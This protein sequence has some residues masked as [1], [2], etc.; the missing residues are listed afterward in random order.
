[1]TGTDDC[2]GAVIYRTCYRQGPSVEPFQNE[3]EDTPVPNTNDERVVVDI[4]EMK[5][6]RVKH[7]V[8]T[9]E[10]ED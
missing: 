5:E 1:M 7:V 10:R 6:G 2:V 9:V 4:S 3:R 8:R